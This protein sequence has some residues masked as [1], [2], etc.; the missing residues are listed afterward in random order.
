MLKFTGSM[1][2]L[3][4]ITAETSP[5]DLEEASIRCKPPCNPVLL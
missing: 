1:N 5:N 3:A 4:G 2:T